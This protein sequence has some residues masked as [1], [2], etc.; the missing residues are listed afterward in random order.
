MLT[1]SLKSS[2]C[3]EVTTT[4]TSDVIRISLPLTSAFLIS[5]ERDLRKVQF[6]YRNKALKTSI[7]SAYV[8]CSAT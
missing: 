7:L 4:N 5:A 2:I 1:F 3:K 6:E 8:L